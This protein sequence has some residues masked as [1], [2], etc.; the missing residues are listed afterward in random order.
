MEPA[1]PLMIDPRLHEIWKDDVVVT[2]TPLPGETALERSIL[3]LATQGLHLSVQNFAQAAHYK[4]FLYDAQQP[5][6]IAYDAC[7]VCHERVIPASCLTNQH[8]QQ[9]LTLGLCL[10]CGFFQHSRRPPRAWYADYY[11]SLW[12]PN[13]RDEKSWP[14]GAV[15]RNDAIAKTYAYL[16]PGAKVLEVGSGWGTAIAAFDVAG[17]PSFSVE[18][19][20]HRSAFIRER[21]QIPCLT[22]EIELLP[23]GEDFLQAESFDLIFSSNVL[24]HVYNTRE[25]IERIHTL[26]KPGGLAYLEL[27]NYY[28]ENLTLNTH[29]IS[30]TCNFSYAN[31]LFLL[32][33]VGFD[34]VRDHSYVENQR[35]LVRKAP[36]LSIEQQQDK[37]DWMRTLLPYRGLAHLL[38][39]NGLSCLPANL[40]HDVELNMQWF[41]EAGG[42]PRQC[43]INLTFDVLREWSAIMTA[44]KIAIVHRQ[45]LADFAPL[46]PIQYV[47]RS[48]SVP[49]W[50]Y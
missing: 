8:G 16:R 42:M 49:I 38:E 6:M 28:Q 34:I 33:T 25:V 13:A 46:L 9:F 40:D 7:V 32:Q 47:Y 18:A 20:S 4:H 30:H 27:P 44:L 11:R 10:Q 31:F 14:E 22:G 1:P 19:T 2:C 35:L 17:F 23:L 36:P 12:D 43:F 26:L 3:P 15:C 37:L 39:K 50:Y 45:P 5:P 29:G 41:L 48:D 24:E 21:L